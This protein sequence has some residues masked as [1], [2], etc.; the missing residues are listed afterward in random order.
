MFTWGHYSALYVAYD[1]RAVPL[2]RCRFSIRVLHQFCTDP[3][4]P[5]NG[6]QQCEQWGP[7]LRFRACSVQC[8]P[9]FGF[10]HPPA[11]FYSCADDGEWRPNEAGQRPFRYPQC[12]R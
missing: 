3:E 8:H 12:T 4:A 9:G 10:S 5:L 6:L 11:V 2:A 7:A 1:S